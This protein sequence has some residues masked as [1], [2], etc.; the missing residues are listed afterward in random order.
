VI[1][2]ESVSRAALAHVVQGLAGASAA[3]QQQ[4]AADLRMLNYWPARPVL[5]VQEQ[6]YFLQKKS[7]GI[8]CDPHKKKKKIRGASMRQGGAAAPPTAEISLLGPVFLPSS[9]V[10]SKGAVASIDGH[11]GGPA[12]AR[13]GP[14]TN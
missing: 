10:A 7:N 8:S 4:G 5:L 13:A 11:S 2:G 12:Q 9:E 3:Q 6:W 1:L 14:S